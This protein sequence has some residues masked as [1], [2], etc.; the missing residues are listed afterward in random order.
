MVWISLVLIQLSSNTT[1]IFF[2]R[3]GLPESQSLQLFRPDL[4]FSSLPVTSTVSGN[5]VDGGDT[6]LLGVAALPPRVAG[7]LGAPTSDILNMNGN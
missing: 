2:R 5:D 4:P 6:S 3:L 7:E 1:Y